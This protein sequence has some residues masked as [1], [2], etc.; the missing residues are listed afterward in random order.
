MKYDLGNEVRALNHRMSHIDDQISQ[1]YNFLSPLN[2]SLTTTPATP[3]PS[4]LDDEIRQ[5]SL[6]APAMISSPG[7]AM[8]VLQA[9]IS[10]LTTSISPD[11][12][13]TSVSMSPLFETPSFYSDLGAR[14]SIFDGPPAMSIIDERQE[15]RRLSRT[16]DQ[17]TSSIP[18]NLTN[19]YENLPTSRSTVSS[20]SSSSSYNRSLS[21]SSN[22]PIGGGGGAAASLSTTPRNSVSNKIAPAPNPPSPTPSSKHPLNTSFQ[23]ISNTR[24][25]PGRSPKP[26][27]RSHQHGRTSSVKYSQQQQQSTIVDLESSSQQSTPTRTAALPLTPGKPTTMSKS[28]S[29]VF[30]RFMTGNEPTERTLI[31]SSS[32]LLYPPTSDDER[33]MSP[34]SSGNDDDDYRPLT[35][36]TSKYHHQTPL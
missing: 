11:T 24:F 17:L 14:T 10:P 25:N 30:R 18:T 21:L 22:T 4:N 28:R 5:T 7:S 3:A 8:S 2:P 9:P 36:S 31:S 34:V 35:S 16:S 23:P 33:P 32:T 1:I 19:P 20:S 15:H 29:N 27:S 6:S 13:I 26:K 12:N